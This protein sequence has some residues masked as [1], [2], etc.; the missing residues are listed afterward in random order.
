M[1]NFKHELNSHVSAHS[2]MGVSYYAYYR[3]YYVSLNSCRR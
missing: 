1:V 2:N 3:Y